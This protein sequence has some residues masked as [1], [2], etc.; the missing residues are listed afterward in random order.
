MLRRGRRKRLAGAIQITG[1]E[2]V[3]LQV[4]SDA[5]QVASGRDP[6]GRQRG[7]R[8]HT[9]SHQDGGRSD[10][11]GGQHDRAPGVQPVDRAAVQS[12]HAGN[13][14]GVVEGQ[15]VD[16]QACAQI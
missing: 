7:A 4:L 10:D 16:E 12:I 3:V 11:S 13:A 9:G 2:Q 15:P 1:R 8:A 6:E 5:R 14:S